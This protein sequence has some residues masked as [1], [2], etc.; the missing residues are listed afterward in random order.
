MTTEVT[1]RPGAAMLVESAV[2]LAAA[3]AALRLLSFARL[4][5]LARGEESRSP[6]TVEEIEPIR[7]SIEG[8]SRRLPWRPRCFE[9][10]LAA[11]WMLGRRGVGSTISYGAA[12]IAGKLKAHVWVHSGTL[13]VI[14]CESLADYALLARFPPD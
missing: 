12:S 6:A 9:Q 5:E 1:R 2:A 14:G 8:W 7:R 10:A 13:D 11:R 3:A 4:V